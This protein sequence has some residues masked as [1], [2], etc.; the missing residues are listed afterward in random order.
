MTTA[1]LSMIAPPP[2][3][4]AVLGALTE[5][6]RIGQVDFSTRLAPEP[7]E[8]PDEVDVAPG[9]AED[10]LDD[11]SGDVLDEDDEARDEDE[12]D[13]EDDEQDRDQPEVEVTAR[14]VTL[15]SVPRTH[16]DVADDDEA[17]Q[18]H[19]DHEEAEAGDEPTGADEPV[20][21][22]EIEDEP[23]DETPAT[24]E[25]VAAA[26]GVPSPLEARIHAPATLR[27]FQEP[28]LRAEADERPPRVEEIARLV[29]ERMQDAELSMMRHLEAIE[30]EAARRAELLT[31]QAELDAELIRLNAR[32][33]AHS[34]VTAA[35]V[36]AGEPA[37]AGATEDRRLDELAESLSRF[38]EVVDELRPAG[39]RTVPWGRTP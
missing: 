38:A 33:E 14:V 32:R 20:M 18:D 16:D 30:A 1:Q 4:A 8:V 23:Q 3:V 9:G 29:I 39:A 19:A 31:A 24:R 35:R 15:V 22:D 7:E 21:E 2:S 34:I 13:D 12:T 26:A 36:R 10:D 27:D 37:A 11:E 17:D 6:T 25:T 28:A 5:E